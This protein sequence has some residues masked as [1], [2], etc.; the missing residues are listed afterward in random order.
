V[1]GHVCFIFHRLQQENATSTSNL[2]FL[3]SFNPGLEQT[4]SS[5]HIFSKTKVWMKIFE[6]ELFI[7]TR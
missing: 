2:L 5:A 7:L 4:T 1:F 6:E 3:N